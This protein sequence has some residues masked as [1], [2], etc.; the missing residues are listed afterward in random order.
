MEETVRAHGMMYKAVDQSVILNG[1]DIW[2]VTGVMLK[3]LEG[4][5]HQSTIQIMR[6][7]ETHGAVG[8]WEYTPMVLALE[9]IVL[10]PIMEYIRVVTAPDENIISIFTC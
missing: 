9:A 4:F 8:E 7:T 6:M 5:H 2:V 10:H 1:S 3:F